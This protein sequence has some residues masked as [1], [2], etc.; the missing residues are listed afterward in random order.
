MIRLNEVIKP[1]K[2]IN[3]NNDNGTL[4]LIFDSEKTAKEFRIAT[5]GMERSFS[6]KTNLVKDSFFEFSFEYTMDNAQV[7]RFSVVSFMN[8]ENYSLMRESTKE[9]T[10]SCR[11]NIGYTQIIPLESGDLKVDIH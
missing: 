8:K 3:W 10:W 9:N 2:E 11:M 7:T 4:T 1:L 5:I 6:L